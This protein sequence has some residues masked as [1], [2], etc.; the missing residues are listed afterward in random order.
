MKTTRRNFI[1][2][3]VFAAVFA[4]NGLASRV[5]AAQPSAVS[6]ELPR[7]V[8]ADRLFYLTSEDFKRQIGAPF[9][10]IREKE[11]FAAE[12]SSVTQ[13]V[14]PPKI[15]QHL[16]GGSRRKLTK[17]T[18]TLS[19][20]SATEDFSQGTYQVWHPALGQFDLF[21]VPGTGEAGQVLVHAVINRI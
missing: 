10:L 19:F 21:L 17:E 14:R 5:F 1:K 15:A 18:F 9:S 3:S 2:A 20:R 12:L 6:D 8:L 7:E 13:T 16:Y 11:V 4:G